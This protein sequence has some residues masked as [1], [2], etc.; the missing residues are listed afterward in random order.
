MDARTGEVWSPDEMEAIKKK[1]DEGRVDDLDPH[2]RR[3]ILARGHLTWITP[4]VAEQVER[5]QKELAAEA[6]RE[7][8]DD[9]AARLRQMG[10]Y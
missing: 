1:V 9:L 7:K 8:Q 2:E 10:G 3:F 4:E 5:G 6:I